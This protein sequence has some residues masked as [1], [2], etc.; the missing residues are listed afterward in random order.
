MH[1]LLLFAAG[2]ATG[3][4]STIAGGGSFISLSVLIFLGLP[5]ATANGTNR[6]AVLFQS[7][8]GTAGFY[9]K[10]IFLFPYS[11]W[12][13]L[14]A[15][16]G[17]VIG[18]LLAVN[19]SGETFD[20]I[21]A[22]LMI[23]F[24]I[25]II[26]DPVGR[27]GDD[28]QRMEGKHRLIA[29][30]TFFFIGI[31]GGFIQSGVG[32][33]IILALR[34][35]NRFSIVKTNGVKVFVISIYTLAALAVFIWNREINWIYGFIVAAGTAIGGWVTSRWSTRLNDKVVRYIIAVIILLF[36]IRLWFF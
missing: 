7:A 30:V 20:R 16:P 24:F 26:I 28:A 8:S 35:I 25:A 2:L 17:A 19:I 5:P 27:T 4:V 13:A 31:Y 33:I 11:L 34:Y 23:L 21:L 14:A 36:A 10:G 15:V 18:A 9:S 1:Y 29:I 32:I 6:I 3:I 12:L 22:A